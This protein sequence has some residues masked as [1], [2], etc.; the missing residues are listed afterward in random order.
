MQTIAQRLQGSS[1]V[2]SSNDVRLFAQVCTLTSV[3]NMSTTRATCGTSAPLSHAA[4]FVIGIPV[5][6]PPPADGGCFVAH[7]V[8]HVVEHDF[9]LEAGPR[10]RVRR[11]CRCGGGRSAWSGQLLPMW[12]ACSSGPAGCRGAHGAFLCRRLRRRSRNGKWRRIGVYR[13]RDLRIITSF[14]VITWLGSGPEP[15]ASNRGRGGTTSST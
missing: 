14:N 12:T 8:G 6:T 11:W 10:R 9:G 2:A 4:D 5:R 7:E 3:P 13:I 15:G 1:A